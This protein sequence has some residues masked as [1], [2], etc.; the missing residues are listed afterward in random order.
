MILQL[1]ED[2]QEDIL[3]PEFHRRGGRDGLWWDVAAL[4]TGRLTCLGS[5]VRVWN[6]D[7][8][9]GFNSPQSG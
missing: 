1:E 9:S 5:K 6:C 7:C 2:V 4:E 3:T 8:G